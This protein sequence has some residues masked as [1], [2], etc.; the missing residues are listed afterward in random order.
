MIDRKNFEERFRRYKFTDFRWID[1]WKIIISQWVRMKCMYGCNEYGVTATCPPNVP[2]VSECERF[3]R[4][5][6]EAVVFHFTKKVAK[7][8]DRFA[9][10]RKINLRLLKLER[11]IFLSGFKKTFLLFLDSCNICPQCSGKK[12]TC[13]KPNIARP[14]PEAMS[15]DVYATVRQIGYPIQVL[16]DY[17]Q[18]MNRYAFLMLE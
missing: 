17:S 10:T 14:T 12:E 18:K 16:T 1:P 11:E 4:E 5:Y 13:K 8:E 15:V 6:D 3:F 2:S 9:W 7:P